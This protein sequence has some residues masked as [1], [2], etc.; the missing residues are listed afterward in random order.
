MPLARIRIVAWKGVVCVLYKLQLLFLRFY[1][2]ILKKRREDIILLC[3]NEPF[4]AVKK[5]WVLCR[6]SAGPLLNRQDLP[7][8]TAAAALENS[9]L[10]CP[11]QMSVCRDLPSRIC[12][13]QM[14][15]K[16][17]VKLARFAKWARCQQR[18]LKFIELYPTNG[19]IN[20]ICVLYTS[21][22]LKIRCILCF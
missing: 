12:P 9:S 18:N 19:V 1:R 10:I 22:K 20:M 13:G 4:A 11:G 7:C 8:A 16:L 14:P 2:V 3:S 6:R 15:W 21:I 5:T 17:G